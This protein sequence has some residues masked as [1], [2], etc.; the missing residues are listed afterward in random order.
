MDAFESRASVEVGPVV[1]E[2]IEGDELPA[3][4]LRGAQQ[5]VVEDLTLAAGEDDGFDKIDG[6][7]L[8]RLQGKPERTDMAVRN[9]T[10]VADI[11]VRPMW[12]ESPNPM[13]V[14]VLPPSMD[15]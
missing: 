9:A 2:A 8:I 7:P 12:R 15:L 4:L 5:K 1:G 13:F 6:V 11:R 10:G 3:R 14:Q